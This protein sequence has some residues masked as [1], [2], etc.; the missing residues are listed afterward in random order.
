MDARS[1]GPPE[2]RPP[3]QAMA[4]SA[5]GRLAVPHRTRSH[6]IRSVDDWPPFA[7]SHPLRQASKS[8]IERNLSFSNRQGAGIPRPPAQI[9]GG[10]GP[11][12][13]KAIV[14]DVRAES[15]GRDTNR[16]SSG[17]ERPVQDWWVARAVTSLAAPRARGRR[18]LFVAQEVTR[19]PLR[20]WVRRSKSS[21][22]AA[23]KSAPTAKAD[24]RGPAGRHRAAAASRCMPSVMIPILA[25]APTPASMMSMIS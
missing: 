10:C 22:L 5:K 17:P 24:V 12:E 21:P 8:R 1:D 11:R 25:P 2:M 4:Y 7:I 3:A 9:A 13:S 23:R 15:S 20:S 18:T 6:L 16:P 19:E 14:A